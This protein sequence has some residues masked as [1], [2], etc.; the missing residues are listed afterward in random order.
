MFLPY[1]KQI[2][3]PTGLLPMVIQPK[4]LGLVN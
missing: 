2:M 3:I 4:E 1:N